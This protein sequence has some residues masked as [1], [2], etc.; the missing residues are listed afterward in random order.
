MKVQQHLLCCFT[1]GSPR[2]FH[3]APLLLKPESQ[4]ATGG[5]NRCIQLVC[6]VLWLL[7]AAVVSKTFV[8]SPLLLVPSVLQ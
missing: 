1:E 8:S 4:W 6:I 2:L 7:F 3:L 5:E